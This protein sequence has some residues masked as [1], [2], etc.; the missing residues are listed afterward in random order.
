[1][2]LASPSLVAAHAVV[3]DFMEKAEAAARKKALEEA[4]KVCEKS[5]D[6]YGDLSVQF[7]RVGDHEAANDSANRSWALS[8]AAEKIRALAKEEPRGVDS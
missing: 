6:D 8:W 3:L 1:M 5:K 7:R 4:A 2:A